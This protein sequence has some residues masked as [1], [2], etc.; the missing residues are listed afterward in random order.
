MFTAFLKHTQVMSFILSCHSHNG[1]RPYT[2]TITSQEGSSERDFS[3]GQGA[4]LA[5]LCSLY[6]VCCHSHSS[7]NSSSHTTSVNKY[8]LESICCNLSC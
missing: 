5:H 6:P 1:L 7:Q 8:L 3:G 4:W 2:M